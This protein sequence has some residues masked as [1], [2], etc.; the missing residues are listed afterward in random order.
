VSLVGF[1]IGTAFGFLIAAA[2]LHDYDVIHRALLLQE[3]DVF[4]LMGSA[5]G[6]AAPLVW[7]L[8][9]RGW[10]TPLAGPLSISRSR[11]ERRHVL[12]AAVFG[13]GWAVAGTCPGPALV[14]A[15]SGNVLGVFVMAG[16][17]VGLL[18]RDSFERR[19]PE[20]A[21]SASLTPVQ[22]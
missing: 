5:V 14:M 22:T 8:R 11:V 18:L 7:L 17:V 13:T 1:S 21:S 19:S 4:L 2:R 12:G 16:L 15:A 3:L 10:R 20:P 9:R 6:V